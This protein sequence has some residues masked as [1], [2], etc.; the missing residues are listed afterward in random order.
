MASRIKNNAQVDTGTIGGIDTLSMSGTTSFAIVNV[1][2]LCLLLR[3]F[4]FL[5]HFLGWGGVAG[6][7]AS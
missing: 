3:L 7:F 2:W 4:R 6:K 5:P 1:A